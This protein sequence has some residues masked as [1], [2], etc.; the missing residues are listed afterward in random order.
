M[1]KIKSI[2]ELKKISSK[3][4]TDFCISNGLMKSSKNIK[5][6]KKTKIFNILNEI[7]DTEQ[8]LTEKEL[9]DKSLTNIGT[10]IKNGC[11]FQYIYH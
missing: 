10:A 3:D 11:F 7:N 2:N 5:Y 9:N 8:N 6:D 4:Y 1:K